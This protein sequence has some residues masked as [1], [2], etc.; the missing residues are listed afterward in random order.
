MKVTRNLIVVL[1]LLV[2]ILCE[3]NPGWMQRATFG[4][5]GR[6]RCNSFSIGNKGYMGVGHYNGSGFNYVLADWWEYDPATN[7]WTQK[8][9]YPGNN[10]N[11]NYDMVALGIGEYGY[12][13]GGTQGFSG[14]FYRFDPASNTWEQKATMIDHG[15]GFSGFSVL[16][17]GYY[18]E[19]D[20]LYEYDP[21]LD[22]WTIK[23]A[24]PF[25]LGAW[26]PSF[27]IEDKGYVLTNNGFY[28][29]KPAQDA[30]TP[31]AA[32]PGLS[33]G[34]SV[35]LSQ[36]GKGYIVAGYEGWLSTVVSEVFEYDPTTNQW[37]IAAEFPGNSRRFSAGF[38]INDRSYFGLG[39]N[40]TN[41]NDFWEF[42]VNSVAETTENKDIQFTCYPNPSTDK[43]E[44][45]S[46][47]TQPFEVVIFDY[48]GR[49]VDQIRSINKIVTFRK[50]DLSNG[51]YYYQVILGNKTQEITPFIFN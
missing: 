42:S 4:S 21:T 46:G 24:L 39:T 6:H 14:D 10:G 44:I 43:I 48:F 30:W 25:S 32:F 33:S 7:S 26:K 51:T 20:V 41:F 5:N 49:K 12:L 37:T 40:G 27:S 28:E 16:G 19:G 2:P 22:T 34:G 13:G 35:G 38:T 11:G 31:R 47:G 1:L 29:Y 45:S 23:N 9:D 3:A 17:K 36:N 18:I 8:A 15:S 50:N